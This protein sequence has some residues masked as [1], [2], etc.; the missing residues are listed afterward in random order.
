MHHVLARAAQCVGDASVRGALFD[1]G[2]YPGLVVDAPEAGFVRGA[3]YALHASTAE[4]TLAVLDAYEG[5][6]SSDS[7]PHEYRR[8]LIDVALAD[9]STQPAWT[10]VLNRPIAGMIRIPNG[11]YVAWRRE[12]AARDAV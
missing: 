8:T 1:L 6:A 12:G 10:Y 4:Q 7:Q 2:A 3:L 9:G 5:C 11:D